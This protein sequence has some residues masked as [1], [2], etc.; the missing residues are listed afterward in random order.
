MHGFDRQLGRQICIFARR[1]IEKF[2]D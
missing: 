1:T 2:E